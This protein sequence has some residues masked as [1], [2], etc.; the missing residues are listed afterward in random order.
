MAPVSY[1]HLDVYKRQAKRCSGNTGDLRKVFDIMRSSIE[2]V[3]LSNIKNR[4]SLEGPPAKV[5]LSHV[6]KVFSTL[7]GNFSTK[8]R[9]SK[10]NMQ[11]QLV[12]CS[13]VHR[14]KIDLFQTQT[15]LDEAYDYYSKLLSRKDNIS[16]LK[17]N[18]YFEICNALETCGVVNI[19]QGK[20]TGKTKHVVKLIKANVDKQEFEDEIKKVASLKNYL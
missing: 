10:L 1:T 16:P 7:Q 19:V 13:L 15:S 8:S 12:L 3:E 4:H 2:V 20:S 17:R 6:A 11:Q 14:E 5:T 18:E 9:I